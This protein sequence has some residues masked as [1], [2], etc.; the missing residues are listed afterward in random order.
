MTDNYVWIAEAWCDGTRVERIAHKNEHDAKED[1]QTTT[2]HID[3]DRYD[4]SR[5][6]LFLGED[7]EWH[8]T[9]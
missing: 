6:E 7:I 5:V 1:I 2:S 4:V 9:R 8:V 3:V